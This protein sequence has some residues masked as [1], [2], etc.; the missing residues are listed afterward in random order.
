[1]LGIAVQ[2][3]LSWLILWWLERRNLSCLGLAP[4]RNRIL[5][6]LLFFFVT[7]FLC[8]TGFGLKYLL[9]DRRWLLNPDF[10]WTLVADGIWWN[11]KSVMFEEL[12]FRGALLYIM[13]VRLGTR[14]AIWISAI[15]FG[16]YHWFSHG[17]FGNP[18]GMTWDF[19]MSGLMGLVLGLAFARTKALYAPIAIHLGWNYTQQSL[20]SNGPIGKQILIELQPPEVQLTIGTWLLITF[21]PVI[22]TLIINYWMIRRRKFSA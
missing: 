17:T 9:A 5:D 1:M 16:M 10:T 22:S 20:F 21:F 18:V 7:A 4:S 13:I 12:I 14:R 8:S 2:L 3:G 15:G 11:I 6:F 19:V